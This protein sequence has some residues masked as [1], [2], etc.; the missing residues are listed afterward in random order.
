M[1]LR[2]NR[3]VTPENV[4]ELQQQG[5]TIIPQMIDP[6]W[7]DELRASVAERLELEG[8]NAG[9]EF[10]REAN[11]QRLANLVDK[12]ETFRRVIAHPELLA[13]VAVV[14]GPDW[15]LSSLNY[16]AALPGQGLQPLHC[17]MG[18]VADARGYAVFNSVWL[19]DDFTPDNGPTRLV[20]GTHRSGR[21]PHEALADPLAPHPDEIVTLGRAGDVVLTNASVWHGGTV[22]RSARPRRSLHGFYVRGDLPQQQYQKRLLRPQTQA[23]LSPVLRRVLALDDPRNDELSSAGSGRSGFLR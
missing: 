5:Y 2:Y 15:K 1:A 7:L 20:P 14:L 8:E 16:R 12:G 10:R 18:Q 6:A 9:G 3:G 23:R 17:D 4:Q 11:A 22:N 21:L 19:L 13:A